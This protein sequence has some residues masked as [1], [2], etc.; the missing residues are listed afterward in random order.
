MIGRLAKDSFEINNFLNDEFQVFFA[1]LDLVAADVDYQ[2][3]TIDLSDPKMNSNKKT[4]VRGQEIEFVEL[5]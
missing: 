5:C 3:P 2:M 1:F 4:L